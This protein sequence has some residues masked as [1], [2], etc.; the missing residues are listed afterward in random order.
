[1]HQVDGGP[2]QRPEIIAVSTEQHEVLGGVCPE[3]RVPSAS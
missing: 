2:W 3:C 1:M